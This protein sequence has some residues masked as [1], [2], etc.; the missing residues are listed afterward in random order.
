MKKY[1]QKDS[2]VFSVR[3]PKWLAERVDTYCAGKDRN[4]NWMIKKK[5]SE[6]VMGREG[7]INEQ[8]DESD[9][10]PTEKEVNWKG[11]KP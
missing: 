2:V 1:E 4:R 9:D 7:L 10:V 6:A 8:P 11:S 5:M 3:W